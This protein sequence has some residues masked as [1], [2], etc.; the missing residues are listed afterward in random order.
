MLPHLKKKTVR[1]P[2]AFARKHSING[3]SAPSGS[4]ASAVKPDTTLTNVPRWQRRARTWRSWIKRAYEEQGC[5]KR[6]VR[7]Y[8][9]QG[10]R[11]LLRLRSS[12]GEHE[13]RFGCSGGIGEV[14][15]CEIGEIEKR[16]GLLTVLQQG[17]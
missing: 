13:F 3:A 7:A 4:V 2:A 11:G 8:E 10:C 17:T 16:L 5:R 9:E 1:S 14:I 6:I 12:R 15:D